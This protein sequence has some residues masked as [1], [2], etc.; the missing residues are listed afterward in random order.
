MILAN[1]TRTYLADL[2]LFIEIWDT[3]LFYGAAFEVSQ[4]VVPW[5]RPKAGTGRKHV[6]SIVEET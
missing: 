1:F 4:C 6:P 3:V 5:H 2:C